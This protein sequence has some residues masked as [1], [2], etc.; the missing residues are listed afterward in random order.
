[1]PV[2]LLC[3]QCLYGGTQ[4]SILSLSY[5][6]VVL[7]TDLEDTCI[8]VVIPNLAVSLVFNNEDISLLHGKGFVVVCMYTVTYT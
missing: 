1:M 2:T 5:V 7:L 6:L 4:S 3:T 8:L